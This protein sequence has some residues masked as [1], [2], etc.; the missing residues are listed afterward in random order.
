MLA[1][2][3][4]GFGDSGGDGMR[5]TTAVSSTIVRRIRIPI[6]PYFGATL[7]DKNFLPLN[8]FDAIYREFI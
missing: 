3:A 1:V 2:L 6:S 7:A 5:I 4:S 8:R